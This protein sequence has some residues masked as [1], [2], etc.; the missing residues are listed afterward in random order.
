M[1]IAHK[2]LYRI[3]DGTLATTARTPF[4][5]EY[6]SITP[7]AEP[8]SALLANGTII[9]DAILQPQW[10]TSLDAGTFTFLE[11]EELVPHRLTQQPLVPEWLLVMLLA[12][13]VIASWYR[14]SRF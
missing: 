8:L 1:T 12:L 7:T 6:H 4:G 9:T 13:S 2:G 14:E 5:K 10:D 11:H 3:D